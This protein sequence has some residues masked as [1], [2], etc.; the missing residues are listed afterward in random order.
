MSSK[1]E[2]HSETLSNPGTKLYRGYIDNVT[3]P[4]PTYNPDVIDQLVTTN[5]NPHD[6]AYK[7]KLF[8]TTPD[9]RYAYGVV[10]ARTIVEISLQQSSWEMYL[11]GKLNPTVDTFKTQV[12]TQLYD[13]EGKS[14]VSYQ[15]DSNDNPT[16]IVTTPSQLTL[17]E[18]ETIDMDP[19]VRRAFAHEFLDDT[20]LINRSAIHLEKMYGSY[21]NYPRHKQLLFGRPSGRKRIQHLFK[22]YQNRGVTEENFRELYAKGLHTYIVF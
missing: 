5:G 8:W 15:A 12:D 9:K 2:A 3:T 13:G 11:E 18:S 22:Y 4:K 1:S 10:F 14:L 17:L 16:Q 7:D 21:S 6:A 19:S 20:E